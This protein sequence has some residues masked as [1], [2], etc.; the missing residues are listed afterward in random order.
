MLIKALTPVPHAAV[1]RQDAAGQPAAGWYP[2]EAMTL[3]QALRCFTLDAAWAGHQEHAT[4]SLEKGKWADFIV[5]D[6][7]LFAI[8]AADIHKV[9]VLQTWV[10]GRLV[11]SQE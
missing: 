2:N 9:G 11:F 3:K 1:T 4:G 8:P 10:G 6:R 7:D 5:V